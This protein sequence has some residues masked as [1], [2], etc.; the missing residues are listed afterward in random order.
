MHNRSTLV[1]NEPKIMYKHLPLAYLSKISSEKWNKI[2]LFWQR[3]DV[4]SVLAWMT[5]AAAGQPQMVVA[6]RTEKQSCLRAAVIKLCLFIKRCY[7]RANKSGLA[8]A[9]CS[10]RRAHPRAR[11]MPVLLL[12]FGR[13][14]HRRH[15]GNTIC[16][17]HIFLP[18]YSPRFS[19]S[20]HHSVSCPLLSFHPVLFNPDGQP[21]PQ[22][23]SGDLQAKTSPCLQMQYES[24]N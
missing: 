14:I 9:G 4:H 20:S 13:P 6:K 5:N 23:N 11:T 10:F 12:R 16:G 24:F 2:V 17:W 8:I 1:N 7:D 21:L 22:T 3:S 15:R 18:I 19:S